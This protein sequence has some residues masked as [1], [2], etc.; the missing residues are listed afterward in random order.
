MVDPRNYEVKCSGITPLLIGYSIGAA[1]QHEWACLAMGA[2]GVLFDFRIKRK[3][4][5]SSC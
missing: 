4:E 3:Q 2:I 1:M 5:D